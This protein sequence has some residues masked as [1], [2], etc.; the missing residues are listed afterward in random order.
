[1]IPR[2]AICKSYLFVKSF[3]TTLDAILESD[4]SPV[5]DMT[6]TISNFNLEELLNTDYESDKPDRSVSVSRSTPALP[7]GGVSSSTVSKPTNNSS[8]ADI[9]A[10]NELLDILNQQLS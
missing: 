5:T 10:E 3:L 6:F 4:A 9:D 7:S 2:Y 1:M 8:N